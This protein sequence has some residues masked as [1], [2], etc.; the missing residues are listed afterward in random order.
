MT[1]TKEQKPTDTIEFN[2]DEIREGAC[3]IRKLGSGKVA[4]CKEKGKIKILEVEKEE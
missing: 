2:P 4:I 1:V 3:H